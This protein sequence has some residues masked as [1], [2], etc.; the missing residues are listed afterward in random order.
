METYIW[1]EFALKRDASSPNLIH[2][3]KI[4]ITCALSVHTGCRKDR[5]SFRTACSRV[6]RIWKTSHGKWILRILW[7]YFLCDAFAIGKTQSAA[8]FGTIDRCATWVPLYAYKYDSDM[9]ILLNARGKLLRI[10][11]IKVSRQ[12]L[13]LQ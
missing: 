6:Q 10:P 11:F 1:Y 7:N 4:D 5:S 3:A 8:A 12:S 13:S 2:A 9:E